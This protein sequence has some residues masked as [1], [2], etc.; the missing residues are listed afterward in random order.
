[1]R[2]Q[3]QSD[4]FQDHSLNFI[5]MALQTHNMER[6][7]NPD[8]Y[9]KRTGE[10]GDTVEFF[11]IVRGGRL[12]NVAFKV[13]GC[14]NTVACSNTVCSM[15]KEKTVEQAW[16]VSPEQVAR[17]LKTLPED[18][19]HCAQLAVGALYLALTSLKKSCGLHGRS[20]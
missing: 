5:E 4:F 8:G 7:Q 9:G 13:D 20:I 11:I 3:S 14:L 16:E 1:M 17:F 18:H 15:V 19:F 12:M 2:D 10:C 6:I